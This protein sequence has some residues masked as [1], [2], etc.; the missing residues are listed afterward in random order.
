VE[1]R[2]AEER[3]ERLP[4]L[5]A[6]L[7]RLPANVIFAPTAL[8]ARAAKDAT[9]TIPIVCV[10]YDPVRAGLVASLARPGGNVTGLSLTNSILS[11]KRLELLKQALPGISRVGVLAYAAGT[12]LEHDWADTREAGRALGLELRRHDVQALADFEG[13]FAAA[14]AWGT[15]AL[16]FLPENFFNRHRGPLLDLAARYQL[17][18]IYETRLFTEAGGF[19]SYGANVA[20]LYRRAAAYVDKILKGVKPSDLPV[21]QPTTFDFLINLKTSQALGLT[22]PESVLQQATELIE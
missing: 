1:Y 6:E 4:D 3:E 18:A 19:M 7:V 22:I 13:G 16:V 21:E 8:A 17:P 12:T 14:A 15:E 9:G 2:W 20:D 5:A 10:S 11:A